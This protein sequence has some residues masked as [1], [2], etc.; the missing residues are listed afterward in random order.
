VTNG[1]PDRFVAGNGRRHGKDTLR[2]GDARADLDRLSGATLG[3]VLAIAIRLAQQPSN[4]SIQGRCRAVDSLAAI[5]VL[6][7]R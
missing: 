3:S 2:L 7:L 1:G 5:D 4:Q 6:D